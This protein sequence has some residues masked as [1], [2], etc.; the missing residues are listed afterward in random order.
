MS[1]ATPDRALESIRAGFLH[2]TGIGSHLAKR[3]AAA[4]QLDALDD[5]LLTDLDREFHERGEEAEPGLDLTALTKVDPEFSADA[6]LLIAR[7]TF[8]VMQDTHS[9][10]APSLDADIAS[11]KVTA[12]SIVSGREQTVVRFAIVGEAAP[13]TQDW[14]FERDPGVDTSVEDEQH[15]VADGG[16]TVAHRGWRLVGI[17]AA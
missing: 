1:D 11:A 12:A 2:V 6:F 3:E 4:E 5:K 13:V 14:T 15:E 16:W 17:A 9:D 8:R 10:G 7:D